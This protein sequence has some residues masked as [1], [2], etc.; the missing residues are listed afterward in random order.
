VLRHQTD[1]NI[2]T[3]SLGKNSLNY[4]NLTGLA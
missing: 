2:Q 3:F 4:Q 1:L